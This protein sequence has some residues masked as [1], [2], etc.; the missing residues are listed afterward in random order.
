M[1]NMFTPLVG[2]LGGRAAT[3]SVLPE[4]EA[5]TM[6]DEVDGPPAEAYGGGTAA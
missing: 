1:V 2:T 5:T 4:R 3:G 6:D